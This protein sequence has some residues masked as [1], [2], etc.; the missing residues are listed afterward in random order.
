MPGASLD[1]LSPYSCGLCV[2][3]ERVIGGAG[4]ET[5]GVYIDFQSGDLF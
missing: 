5:R 1:D 4:W 3:E 2:D